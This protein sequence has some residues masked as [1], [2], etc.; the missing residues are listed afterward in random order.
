MDLEANTDN[1]QA[2]LQSI[3]TL[4]TLNISAT[5]QLSSSD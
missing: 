5:N 4:Q 2:I 1:L 3:T